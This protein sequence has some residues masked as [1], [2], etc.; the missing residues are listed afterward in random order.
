MSCTEA[1]IHYKAFLQQSERG[2][3]EQKTE[4]SILP[5]LA[6]LLTTRSTCAVVE[7]EAR[8]GRRTIHK[9]SGVEIGR[10]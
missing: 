2:S 6:H 8:L 7:S 4:Q 3:L 5:R 10:G 1:P 9:E